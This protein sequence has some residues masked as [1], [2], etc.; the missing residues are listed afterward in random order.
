MPPLHG[1]WQ[2]AVMMPEE[3]G[4]WVSDAVMSDSEGIP[5]LAIGPRDHG[6]SWSFRYS[7]RIA[8]NHRLVKRR[9]YLQRLRH[10]LG[11]ESPA[12]QGQVHH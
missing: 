3:G 6:R 8:R 7:I 5:P 9:Q 1:V 2:L 11:S 10:P 4:V 12:A